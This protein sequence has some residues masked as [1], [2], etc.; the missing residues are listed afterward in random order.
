MISPN[1][2]LQLKW[3]SIKH[4]T[5]GLPI[6]WRHR[7]FWHCCWILVRSYIGTISNHNQ[8][9]LCVR[10]VN[11]SNE[12]NCLSLN[13]R[14]EA[15]YIDLKQLVMQTTHMIPNFLQIHQLK[16]NLFYISRREQQE[17]LAS[18]WTQIKG[19]ISFN[20]AFWN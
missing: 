11:R 12:R 2:K 10:N 7:R 20:Q 6:W 4:E 9:R 18:T 17:G 14:K 15:D 5:I 19:T 13:K 8:S 16:L 3:C 1:K